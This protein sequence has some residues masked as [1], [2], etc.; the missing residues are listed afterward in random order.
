MMQESIFNLTN[1]KCAGCVGKVQA[2]VNSLTG[3]ASAQVNLLDKTLLVRYTAEKTDEEVIAALSAV[4]YG[5]SLD[6]LAEEH[7]SLLVSVVLPMLIAVAMMALTMMVCFTPDYHTTTGLAIGLVYAALSLAVLI[8]CGHK[9]IRSGYLGFKSLAFNMHSLILL[10]V[11]SAWIYSFFVIMLIHF[12]TLMVM[13]HV[14]FDSSLMII[15]LINLGAYLEDK[16]KSNTTNAIKALANLVPATTIIIVDG[17]EQELASNLLRTDYLVKIK[18]GSII[19]A[20]GEI[21]TGDGYLDESMLTGESMPLHKQI[22][23]KVIGGSINTSGSLVFKVTGIGDNTLL[24]G[25][26][27]L[28]KNA[29][30]AKPKLAKLADKIA[31]VFVPSIIAIAFLSALLWYLLSAE[32]PFYHAITIFMT[33]LLIA[34]PCSVGLAIPVSLMVGVGRGASKGILI[35]DPSCLGV[36]DKVNIVLLDKT[37]TIT[38]GKPQV[39]QV[40]YAPDY[41]REQLIA[42]ILAL[43]ANSEHPL[44]TAIST[45]FADESKNS[46]LLPM[47]DF[48]SLSGSGVAG[49]INGVQYYAGSQDWMRKLALSENGLLSDSIHSQIYLA[50][51][52]EVLLCIDIADKIKFDSALAIAKLQAKSLTVAMLTGDNELVARDIAA[53][54][55]IDMVFANCKP[56][57]KIKHV[58][59]LQQAGNKVVFVGDGINDTPSLT[60]ADIGIAIGGGT[61]IA[62]QSAT[63]SLMQSSLFGVTDA[64]NLAKQINSNMRQNLFGSFIYN[65]LAV[66]VAAGALYPLWGILLNPMIASVVMSLSSITVISN[67]LRLRMA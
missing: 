9:I 17:N 60:Q 5:A 55:N 64:L 63:I 8:A 6:A 23:D 59:E 62:Q 32:F 37:G 34:C 50:N 57:D 15:A 21:V 4:G 24:S 19:P 42:T 51:D 30:L 61:D 12:S 27:N 66:V 11:G 44:A 31:A 54:V 20:D 38:E 47:S 65:S 18:P 53:Q 10:G 14:Y 43:E 41:E 36:A 25:I 28:V 26:I 33:V 7:V 35:R 3:I 22:G 52:H 29:Q 1:V 2:K 39:V 46:K 16:A 56:E 40:K 45:H 13:P 67:A 48:K 58:I 49:V